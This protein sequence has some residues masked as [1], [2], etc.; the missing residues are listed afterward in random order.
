MI[1]TVELAYKA[2]L[3]DYFKEG[4]KYGSASR[5]PPWMDNKERQSFYTGKAEASDIT[6]NER[7]G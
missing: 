3:N 5:P 4:K 2:G 6:R 7:E 1:D